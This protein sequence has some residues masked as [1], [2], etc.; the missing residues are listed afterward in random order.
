MPRP[1]FV[2]L[3]SVL[4]AMS[5]LHACA[6]TT[7]SAQ[8]TTDFRGTI[9]QQAI[10]MTVEYSGDVVTGAHLRYENQAG[11]IALSD[12]HLIGSTI[13]MADADG[14]VFHLHL[15]RADGSG[16]SSLEKATAMTGLMNRDELE[17]PV[18]VQRVSTKP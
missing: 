1:L 12:G 10:R 13:V 11:E 6:Q 4:F 3:F 14:N 9:G 15:K 7:L 8:T 16:T 5:A 17:L 2:Q 18:N